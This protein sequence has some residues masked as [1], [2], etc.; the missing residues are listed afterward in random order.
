VKRVALRIDKLKALGFK[1]RYNSR[2]AVRLTAR[3]LLDQ[4]SRSVKDR[5]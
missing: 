2:E 1:P 3:A 5:A 4:R